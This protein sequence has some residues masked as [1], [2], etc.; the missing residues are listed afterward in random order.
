MA[1]LLATVFRFVFFQTRSG[2]IRSVPDESA[3]LRTDRCEG[4]VCGLVHPHDTIPLALLGY[5]SGGPR[6]SRGRR[7]DT[8]A[9]VGAVPGEHLVCPEDLVVNYE[10]GWLA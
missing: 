3:P 2:P 6:A 8:P 4:I 1:P 9:G 10:V 7:V 5:G